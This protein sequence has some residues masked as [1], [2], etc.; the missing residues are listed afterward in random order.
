[1]LTTKIEKKIFIKL[2]FI[3]FMMLLKVAINQIIDFNV[4][5]RE[6]NY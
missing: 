6:K 1:M 2:F 4:E 3:Y 5:K